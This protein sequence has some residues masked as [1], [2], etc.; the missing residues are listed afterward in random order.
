[1]W[2]GTPYALITQLQIQI[3]LYTILYSTSDLSCSWPCGLARRL[4]R[5]PPDLSHHANTWSV[6]KNVYVWFSPY[7]SNILLLKKCVT[8]SGNLKGINVITPY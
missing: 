1:M 4:E 2:H 8:V 5:A 6:L 3:Y 7:E